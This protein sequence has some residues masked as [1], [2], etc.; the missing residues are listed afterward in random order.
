MKK[1][2][3]V[4]FLFLV[5]PAAG[6]A[7]EFRFLPPAATDHAAQAQSVSQLAVAV[8]TAYRE[9][10]R[11]TYLDNLFR[12]QMVAGHYAEAAQ[13]IAELRAMPDPED[14]PQ[15]R[16]RDAQYEILARAEARHA[17]NET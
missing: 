11:S 5:T 14:P 12:L 17:N 4:I 2:L 10:D 1:W 15:G 9:A 6:A 8:L 7:P 16:A 13:T 3:T